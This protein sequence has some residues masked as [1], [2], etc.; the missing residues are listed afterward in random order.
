VAAYPSVK[1]AAFTERNASM[2]RAALLLPLLLACPARAEELEVSPDTGN[3]SFSAVFDARLGER[4]TAVSSA[5][6]CSGSLDEKTGVVSGS[7]SVPLQSIRVDNDDTKSDHFRQWATNKKSDP[8]SCRIEAVLA[9]VHLGKLVPETPVTFRAEVPFRVC[10]RGRS[11]GKPEQ[12]T[13]TVLLF[14]PGSYGERKTIRVRAAVKGFD[15]DAYQVGPQYT[16]G[17]LARVQSLA[18][19]VAE[20][21]DVELSL[22]ARPKA[23]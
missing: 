9:G 13:G 22:F 18:K 16:E 14:P 15:R 4:I 5:V 10:G 7:C 8:A 11:D 12:V 2:H 3:N 20:K 23:Q 6:G 1:G 19:V 21:G 17:W